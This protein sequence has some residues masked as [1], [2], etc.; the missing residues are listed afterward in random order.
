MAASSR[1]SAPTAS[2]TASSDSRRARKSRRMREL[3]GRAQRAQ[4]ADLGRLVADVHLVERRIARQRQRGE[5]PGVAWRRADV[6]LRGGLRRHDLAVR[7]HEHQ[8]E[9]E[10][11]IAAGVR[12]DR[13]ERLVAQHVG[14]VERRVGRG[15]VAV[16][17]GDAVLVELVA[18]HLIRALVDRAVPVGPAG[19]DL[20]RVP[21]PVAVEVLADVDRVVALGLQPDRQRVLG[22]E[23]LDAAV[24]RH[25]AADA[26]VVRV[27]A[28]EVGRARRAAERIG[29]VVV[30]ERRAGRAD[31]RA[32]CGIAAM[33]R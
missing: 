26:V 15:E 22:V 17:V 8:R 10:R 3:Y 16:G 11:A 5:R 31:Q 24:G 33:S 9:E 12:A 4:A 28:G 7:R 14:L 19:R 1:T 6:R 30:R 32:V 21:Q 23:R 29:D 27:L 13:L 25:C 2:S 20:R 18:P